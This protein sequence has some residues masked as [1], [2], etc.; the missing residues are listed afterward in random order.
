MAPESSIEL[1]I[2]AIDNT[3]KA[4]RQRAIEDNPDDLEEY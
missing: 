2:D 3:I 1:A 4:Y